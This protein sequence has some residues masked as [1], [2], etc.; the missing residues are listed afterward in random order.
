M[1]PGRCVWQRGVFG[2]E[3]EG[4]GKRL[5]LSAGVCL[6]GSRVCNVTSVKSQILPA[7]PFKAAGVSAGRGWAFSLVSGH[8]GL[9][10]LMPN[11]QRFYPA[12]HAING[13]ER[14]TTEHV[15]PHRGFVDGL[16]FLPARCSRAHRRIHENL[17]TVSFEGASSTF[18]TMRLV[19]HH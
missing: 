1:R 7:L 6:P 13:K 14:A 9:D 8:R 3:A 12:S 11:V 2:K 19:S 10:A 15:P 17:T 18:E 5:R 16:H 4:K